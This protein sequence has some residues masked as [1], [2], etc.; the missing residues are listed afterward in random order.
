MKI[1]TKIFHVLFFGLTIIFSV[2][3]SR[4]LRNNSSTPLSEI[5]ISEKENFNPTRIKRTFLPSSLKTTSI[6]SDPNI[7]LRR[8]Q[9]QKNSERKSPSKIF[10]VSNFSLENKS[11]L[12]KEKVSRKLKN[13]VAAR[14][15]S[16]LVESRGKSTGSRSSK[17]TFRSPATTLPLADDEPGNWYQFFFDGFEGAFPDFWQLYGTPTWG[18]TDV[19]ASTG[20]N[21]AWC[22]G[23]D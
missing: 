23:Y 21:S 15:L 7:K 22:A 6:S 2:Q 9:T 20:S 8:F 14:K 3:A 18:P 11:L 1:S 19:E 13:Y 4:T 5:I 10:R 17:R 16:E 12:V